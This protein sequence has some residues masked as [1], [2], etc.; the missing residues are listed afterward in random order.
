MAQGLPENFIE[1]VF[2]DQHGGW[3]VGTRTRGFCLS[4]A[5]IYKMGEDRDGNLWIGTRDS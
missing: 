1:T 3:W 4:T 5:V 2:Q